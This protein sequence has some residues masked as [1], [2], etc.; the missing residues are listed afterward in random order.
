MESY[1]KD[2]KQP[3]LSDFSGGRKIGTTLENRRA[4]VQ[5]HQQHHPSQ[6]NSGKSSSAQHWHS[7]PTSCEHHTL[8]LWDDEHSHAQ[9]AGQQRG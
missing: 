6:L 4:V 8:G 5:Y 9:I 2:G 7:E 3:E 1:V